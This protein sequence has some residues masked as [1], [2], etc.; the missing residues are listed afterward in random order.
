MLHTGPLAMSAGGP[1]RVRGDRKGLAMALDFDAAFVLQGQTTIV[2]GGASGIGLA[3]ARLLASRGSH[4]VILDSSPAVAEVAGALPG[5]PGEHLGLQGDVACREDCERTVAAAVERFGALDSLVNNAGIGPLAPAEEMTDEIFDRTM[6][7]NVRGSFLMARA[8]GNV[9]IEQRRGRIVN[10]ASQ[11]SLI[12]IDKH[13]AY[14]ASKAAVVGMTRVL[15]LEWGRYGLTVNA[16]SPTVVETELARRSWAGE[17]GENL[18]RQIPTGRFAQPEEVAAAVLY[19]I[20]GVAGMI[21]GENLVIDGG[22]T[23]Q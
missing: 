14:C 16:V 10:L 19:L 20:S 6:A 11:A 12:G 7:V 15:A 5:G 3:I 4:L 18:K 13:L 22:F 1:S 2:T 21:N 8:A 23:I 17:I 9:M